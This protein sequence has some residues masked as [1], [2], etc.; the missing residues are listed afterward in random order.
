[1][2]LDGLCQPQDLHSHQGLGNK[3]FP[4]EEIEITKLHELM[5]CALATGMYKRDSDNESLVEWLARSVFS[6]RQQKVIK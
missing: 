6:L 2:G 1:M 5:H 4:K 3:P